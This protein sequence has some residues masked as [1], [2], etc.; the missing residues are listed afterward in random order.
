MRRNLILLFMTSL[1]VGCTSELAPSSPSMTATEQIDDAHPTEEEV[2]WAVYDP[3]PKHPWNRV[4]RQLYR[5][6]TVDGKEYGSAELDPLL[7]LDT[8]Y[9]LHGTSHQQAMQVLDEFLTTH[10]E[11]LIHDS[12]KRAMFQRDMW[13]VF[14]WLASQTEPYSE[15]RQALAARLAQVIKRVA[16]TKEEILLLPDNYAL[17]VKSLAFPAQ[18]QAD[19]PEE[20]FLP[21]DLFQPDSAWVPM[22]R[23][24]GPVAMTHTNSFPFF[25]HSVFLV[26]IRSPEGRAETLDFIESLNR[27]PNPV[28]AIGSDVALVRRM[29]LI[30][31]Q[32]DLTL[33]PL[34]ESIQIRHFS[35][36]QVFHE[37]ELKRARLFDG[38]AG[39]LELKTDLFLL[40]MSHGD[41]FEDPNIPELKAT[42]PEICKACHVEYPPIPNSGNTRS[43]ISYSRHPFPLPD[44]GRPVLSETTS[45]DEAQT[46]IE[47]KLD[48]QTWRSL[49]TLWN[50]AIP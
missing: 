3:N 20:A 10:A 42:I 37:F 31:D 48:H 44:G 19:H 16:L 35:P 36:A 39:G 14:D 26:F 33:S 41:V 47:W 17:A 13:A 29:L 4:F 1:L 2:V 6:T 30:D 45:A 23:V 46:V 12:L 49:E 8:T 34:V 9:L 22:G 24:G 18:V 7:W 21:S 28:T 5:R 38:L 25:G 11:D 27:E 43:I 15:Q 40:F 50:Q 32:G